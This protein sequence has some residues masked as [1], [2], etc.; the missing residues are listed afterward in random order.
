VRECP[1]CRSELADDALTCAYCGGSFAPDGSFKTPWDVEMA[2]MAAAR[3]EKL[4]RAE[5]F[6]RL[7]KP[8]PHLF[9]ESRSGCLGSVMV[10]AAI[11]TLAVI[12][13]LTVVTRPGTGV[14]P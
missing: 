14:T 7:G 8:I 12:L 11:G 10:I 6:G 9:L 2:K 4:S 5:R 3:E 13:G 1:G